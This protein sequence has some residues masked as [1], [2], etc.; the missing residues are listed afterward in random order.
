ME[1]AGLSRSLTLVN[2]L[3][4][5]VNDKFTVSSKLVNKWKA[6][7][8]CS[9]SYMQSSLISIASPGSRTNS[10]KTLREKDRTIQGVHLKII[11]LLE[12]VI[13]G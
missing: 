3:L 2:F 7:V 13:V 6:V 11:C 8:H 5:Q 9:Y 10:R 4:Y 12:R 1:D